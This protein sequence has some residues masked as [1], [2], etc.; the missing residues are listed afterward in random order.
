M[1]ILFSSKLNNNKINSNVKFE[2]SEPKNLNDPA[3]FLVQFVNDNINSNF[4][5]SAGL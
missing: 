1:I 3:D 5:Q 2:T 4:Y